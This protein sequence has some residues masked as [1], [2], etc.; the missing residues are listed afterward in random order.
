MKKI[1]VVESILT[2]FNDVNWN[3]LTITMPQNGDVITLTPEFYPTKSGEKN[4]STFKG[5][6]V[7]GACI[8]ISGTITQV[9]K[10]L[11][12]YDQCIASRNRINR[13]YRR[14]AVAAAPAYEIA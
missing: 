9:V 6:V 1:N 8:P 13:T 4:E 2:V 3:P 5:L 14:K 11:R 10:Q 7:T 12:N